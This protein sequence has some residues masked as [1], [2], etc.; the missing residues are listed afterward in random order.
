MKKQLKDAILVSGV[1]SSCQ[2]VLCII[3]HKLPQFMPIAMFWVMSGILC[4][5]N[6]AAIINAFT[7]SPRE[8]K[9]RFGAIVVLPVLGF[10]ASPDL[11]GIVELFAIAAL[12]VIL[13]FPFYDHEL[14]TQ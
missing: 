8:K 9:Y 14:V 6:L 5:I 2:V 7:Y 10:L 1:M 13:S 12:F 11:T 4:F 3:V